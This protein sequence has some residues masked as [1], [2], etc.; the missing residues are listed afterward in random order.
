M[1]C[2]RPNCSIALPHT[3]KDAVPDAYDE[4]EVRLRRVHAD[5]QHDH[6]HCAVCHLL[7]EVERLRE[8]I[9]FQ[10]GQK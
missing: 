4:Y 8:Q 1:T 9:R 7:G 3:H 6:E 2:A 5:A 10:P